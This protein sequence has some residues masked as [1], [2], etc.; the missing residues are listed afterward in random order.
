MKHRVIP[1][2]VPELACPNQCIYCN[3]R[4]ISG[5]LQI[6]TDEE[7]ISVI[8]RN[9]STF[10]DDTF[11]EL[12]FFGGN[13]TGI[14]IEE[15][16]RLFSLIKP[17]RDRGVIKEVRL[18]T[19]PDY[20]NREIIDFLVENG[21]NTV[22]LGVQS[23]DEE[24]LSIVQRGYTPS[25]V[26]DAARLIRQ[27]GIKLGMQMMVGLPGDTPEK[28]LMTAEKIVEWGAENT[29]IYPT[30]VIQNT[31]LASWYKTGKYKP[32]LL[33]EALHWV[34][35]IL[36]LFE[37]RGVSVLRVGLHPT[38]G[39]IDGKDYMA[40]PF[41]VSFKELVQTLIWNDLFDK[42]KDGMFVDKVS[43]QAVVVEVPAKQINA[44]IGHYAKNKEF[45][46]N[47]YGVRPKFVSNSSL[48]IYT[49]NV[50]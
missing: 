34:K 39:F 43:G 42:D 5:Q 3:Q 9:L 30:L 4:I 18:S 27:V 31:E 11:V 25:Q 24:V 45:I 17:Y 36:Y 22:E 2:F 35:P 29:R 26:Y 15:Q 49:F 40:G 47:K 10:T 16:Q 6:P 50:Q 38:E 7:I 37:T 32:L 13:F 28:S 20:I 46:L 48:P 44:A 19:R 8:E 33:E 21:V 23:L 1:V 14:E 12:G 41:H